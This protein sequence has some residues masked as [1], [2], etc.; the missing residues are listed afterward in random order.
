MLKSFECVAVIVRRVSLSP[1][2]Q[3]EQLL[4][5]GGFALVQ[6]FAPPK[7]LPDDGT[8]LSTLGVSKRDK[9]IARLS[10]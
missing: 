9:F 6:S 1:Y 4:A 8:P 10:S 5:P 7:P 3:V 2:T